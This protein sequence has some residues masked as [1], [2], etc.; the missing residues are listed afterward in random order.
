[1]GN[2]TWIEKI[3]VKFR[4]RKNIKNN[5]CV[6]CEKKYRGE[7]R[8]ANKEKNAKKE[9]VYR[10]IHKERYTL[11][12]IENKPKRN[13]LLNKRYNSDF[14][15]RLSVTARSRI[16]RFI[17]ESPLSIKNSSTKELLCCDW[18]FAKKH[19]EKQFKEVMS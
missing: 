11:N 10:E 7:Y 4:A 9:K 18:I 2:G 13:E 6:D 3:E 14:V 15:Y 19:I 5:T 12:R 17:K 16:K 1:M 8:K